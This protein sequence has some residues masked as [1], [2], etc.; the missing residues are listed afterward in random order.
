M[1]D[2]IN[3]DP[4]AAGSN[5]RT[6]MQDSRP[7][8]QLVMDI[9]LTPPPPLLAKDVIPKFNMTTDM[10]KLIEYNKGKEPNFPDKHVARDS[11]AP[12]A[13]SEPGWDTIRKTWENINNRP[14]RVVELW[15]KRLKYDGKIFGKRP[16]S[17]I[18]RMDTMVP[19]LPMIAI[20]QVA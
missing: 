15:A 17:L 7:N 18:D 11:W 8:P 20:G 6:I 9:T 19:A 1:A 4:A 16:Q 5:P 13:V 14:E 12:R 3:Y 10:Q 2:D